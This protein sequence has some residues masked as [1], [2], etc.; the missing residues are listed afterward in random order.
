VFWTPLQPGTRTDT[1]HGYVP[2]VSGVLESDGQ[3]AVATHGVSCDT[4]PNVVYSCNFNGDAVENVLLMKMC[5][6]R[7]CSCRIVG[8]AR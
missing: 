6:G 3:R 2:V 1:L 4:H 5:P 8:N 7:T